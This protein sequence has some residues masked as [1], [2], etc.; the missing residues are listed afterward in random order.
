MTNLDNNKIVLLLL[1]GG[2]DSPVALKRLLER[3]YRVEG[4]CID[5]IQGKEK[6][7]AQATA[8]KYKI[9]LHIHAISFFD[10]ETWSPIKLIC[11]DI[12]MGFI[13]I[14]K[15]KSI[16]AHAIAVG[17]KKSDIKNPSLWW[18]GPFLKLGR[19]VLRLWGLRLL[20]PAWDY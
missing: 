14:R 20:F 1:S 15:A 6:I 18:L 9:P 8:E 7:G 13:A 3:G 16:G 5:G 10:E 4:L 12:A 19:F 2:K 11:R 17:V